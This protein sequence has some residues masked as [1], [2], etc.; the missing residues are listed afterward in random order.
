MLTKEQIWA[1]YAN[2]IPQ[3]EA[4]HAAKNWAACQEYKW[5]YDELWARWDGVR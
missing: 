3:W 4:A 1:E 2:F 5:R